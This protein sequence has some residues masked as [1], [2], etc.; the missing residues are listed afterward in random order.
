MF[1]IQY[2]IGNGKILNKASEK[3]FLLVKEKEGFAF[4]LPILCGKQGCADTVMIQRGRNIEI[5]SAMGEHFFVNMPKKCGLGAPL[6]C[7][8]GLTNKD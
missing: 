6:K 7:Q 4:D 1:Q 5:F 2:T 8:T 3:N